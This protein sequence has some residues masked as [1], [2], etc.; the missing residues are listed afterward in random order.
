MLRDAWQGGA[1]TDAPWLMAP[2]LALVLT[3]LAMHLVTAG[4]AP[5]LRRPGTFS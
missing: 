1:F 4:G 2:A 3:I 5:T